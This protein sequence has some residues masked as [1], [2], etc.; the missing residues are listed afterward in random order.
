MKMDYSRIIAHLVCWFGPGEGKRARICVK[1]QRIDI[2]Y[3]L[4]AGVCVCVCAVANFLYAFFFQI[5]VLAFYRRI[6]FV[7]CVK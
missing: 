7:E 6:D 4:S 1:F 5:W 2:I 3:I